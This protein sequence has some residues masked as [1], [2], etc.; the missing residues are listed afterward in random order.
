MDRLFVLVWLRTRLWWNGLRSRSG[1]A[2]A[3]A[4]VIVAV[5]AAAM[6]I[7][8]AVAL[9]AITALAL[10]S[11]D[12]QAERVGLLIVTWVLG[13][14]AVI[15]PVIFGVGPSAVP[16]H[17]LAVFPFSRGTLF[18]VSLGASFLRGIHVLWLPS[19]LAV[20]AVF[21]VERG[22][23]AISAVIILAILALCFVVWCHSLLLIVQRVLQ[24]RSLRE[25]VVLVAFIVLVVASLTPAV[26]E[27]Q[28]FGPE[29]ARAPIPDT[30]M[31][32]ISQMAVVFPPSIAAGGLE[33]VLEEHAASS[34]P[35]V[36]WLV[37]WIA[38]G[39]TLGYRV[40]VRSMAEGG[41]PPRKSASS[42]DERN[43][44]GSA[45]GRFSV[46][47]L[48]F[49]SP[50]VRAVATKEIAYLLR[51]T[52]GKFNIVMMPLFVVVVGLAVGRDLTGPVLGI[53]AHSILFLGAM[54]YVS[55]FSNNIIY[56]AFAWDGAGVQSYF[57][58]PVDLRTV[59]VGKNLGLWAVNGV[60]AAEC[61]LSF[62][63]IVGVPV[64]RT[65]VNGLLVFA[66]SLLASTVVGNF[67]SLAF[68]V[69]RDPSKFVGSPSQ[70]GVIASFG[71]LGVNAV[72][73]GALVTVPT[74]LGVGWIQ[75]L[76]LGALLAI[77][78]AA[79]RALLGPAG[80]MMAGRREHLVE[81]LQVAS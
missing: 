63:F 29:S 38:A 45:K 52:L 22:L 74:L 53:D 36:A 50:Q 39:V 51:S 56:N 35:V 61:A 44:G 73:I 7:G 54:L 69:A 59:I 46:D 68:P 27:S 60:F 62:A 17:R 37:L 30:V 78:V 19:L 25:V 32:G 8:L 66:V 64:A 20:C 57:F 80:R 65:L 71:M 15:A 40:H 47:R 70:T 77:L 3:A 21:S 42:R 11:G 79:Y 26:L 2:D 31:K 14:L 49:L 81:A 18:R 72:S 4:A 5:L 10:G 33:S 16:I 75:P 67:V 55:M 1:A 13:F 28:G 48:T 9:A 34:V 41:R 6:S 12:P 58:G 24:R 76:L 23:P 43:R